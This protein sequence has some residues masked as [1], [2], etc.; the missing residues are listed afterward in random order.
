MK[1]V[2]FNELVETTNMFFADVDISDSYQE[3]IDKK[4][5]ELRS[6]MQNINTEEGLLKYV[7]DNEEALD[8]I[9]LLLNVSLETFKRII[10]MFRREHGQEF[11]TEWSMNQ[12]RDYI[13]E[14]EWLRERVCNLFLNGAEDE[15]LAKL[16]PAYT[17]NSFKIDETTLSRLDSRDTMAILTKKSLDTTFSSEVGNANLKRVEEEIRK[18]CLKY[19]LKCILRKK[20]KIVNANIA[21]PFVVEDEDNRVRAYFMCNFSVTTGSGQ[22]N[23]N[24]NVKR[25]KKYRD[26]NNIDAVIVVII[27]G[28]GWLAR[29]S[30][31]KDIYGYADFCLNFR[32]LSKINEILEESI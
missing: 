24:K 12:T 5:M 3:V 32:H 21:L 28:A 25:L 15:E 8:N 6:G 11:A 14:Q 23:F 31:F 27:D 22:S 9:I 17:L 29:Q 19:G 2:C 10:S 4:I 16:I 26:E 13:L 20:L 18:D 1:K 30:D 7:R